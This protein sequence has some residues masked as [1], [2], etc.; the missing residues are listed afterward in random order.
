M[1]EVV[2]DPQQNDIINFTL[3]ISGQELDIQLNEP[4]IVKKSTNPFENAYDPIEESL[5]KRLNAG[6]LF[7]VI[8]DYS[9]TEFFLLKQVGNLLEVPQELTDFTQN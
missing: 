4:V 7:E 8:P 3:K 9:E 1:T 5:Q 6:S 2:A